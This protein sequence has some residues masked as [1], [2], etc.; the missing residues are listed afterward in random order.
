[1]YDPDRYRDKAEVERW[2][3]RDPINRLLDR[4]REDGE[5]V[6]EELAGIER[7]VAAEV[8]H[9]VEAAER[10]PEEPVEHLLHHVTSAPPE[11]S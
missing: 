10:A 1:M 8:D 9:A 11:V 2:K 7:R 5:P 4:M 3:D 6:D